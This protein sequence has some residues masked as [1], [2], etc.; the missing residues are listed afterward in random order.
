MPCRPAPGT[1]RLPGRRLGPGRDVLRVSFT[2]RGAERAT[3]RVAKVRVV[4]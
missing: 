1:L 3:T 2:A 4:R